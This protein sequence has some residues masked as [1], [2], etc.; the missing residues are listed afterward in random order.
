MAFFL[1][2]GYLCGCSP[3]GQSVPA[4]TE[5]APSISVPE[6]LPFEFIVPDRY[7]LTA[8]SYYSVSISQNGQSIG[9]IRH[10]IDLHD[11]CVTDSDCSHLWNYMRT[12]FAPSPLDLSLY[13]THYYSYTSISVGIGY[14]NTESFCEQTHYLFDKDGAYYDF[15]VNDSLVSEEDRDFIFK[16][17]LEAT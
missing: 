2:F 3:I 14:R 12:F 11:V 9:G 10:A 6:T 8:E 17:I 16:S 4:E 1:I 13:I 15:W 5:T 7:K